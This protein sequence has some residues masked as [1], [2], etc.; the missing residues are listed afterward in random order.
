M[1]IVADTAQKLRV[2][3]RAIFISAG[4]ISNLPDYEAEATLDYIRWG[5]LKKVPKYVEDYC[6]DT[7]RKPQKLLKGG[8]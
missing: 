4:L 8:I 2:T 6:L 3:P 1:C 5:R 7:W